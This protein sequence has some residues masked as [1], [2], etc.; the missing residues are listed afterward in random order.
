[1]KIDMHCHTKYSVDALSSLD[2][3]FKQVKEKG[4]DGIAI[5]D[6][7]NIKGWE[8]A[9]AMAKKYDMKVILGEE[10]RS[11]NGDILGLFLLQGIN[12]KGEDPEKIIREIKRQNGIVIIPHPFDFKKPFEDLE[13]YISMIDGIEIFNARRF[14]NIDNIKAKQFTEKYPELVI[15]AGS[16]AHAAPGAGYAYIESPAKNLKEFKKD[17][18][19]KNINWHGKKAPPVYLLVPTLKKI[20][21]LFK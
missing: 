15:T 18:L 6:H 8:D 3:I 2:E 14:M 16:D 20:I 10:V 12:M 13:K 21:N 7:N 17:I 9:V 11:K 5:T 19:S 1:M 4:L